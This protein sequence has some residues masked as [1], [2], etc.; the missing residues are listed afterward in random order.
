MGK[1][2]MQIMGGIIL[3]L[4]AA[5]VLIYFTDNRYSLSVKS[6][7]AL[8]D[9][10]SLDL[11]FNSNMGMG[12]DSLG[13]SGDTI[14]TME[15]KVSYTE[16]SLNLP[17]I[18]NPK[19]VDIYTEDDKVY[20]KYNLSFLPWQEGMPVLQE[21]AFN[22][23]VFGEI[24]TKIN[25]MD[26]LKFAYI[27]DKGKDEDVVEYYTTDFFTIEEMKNMLISVLSLDP[28]QVRS[29]DIKAYEIKIAFHKERNELEFLSVMFDY[30]VSGIILNNSFR[31]N[32]NSL[33][34]VAE[35][36]VPEGLTID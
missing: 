7:M 24:N 11:S 10:E 28:E 31:L 12:E 22:P 33:N 17:A 27:L 5:L 29:W 8:R 25:V 6:Y 9:A 18:G 3:I 2:I 36:P 21:D 14:L 15:P 20:H 19:I 13:I 4:V 23:A 16:V 32:I 30:D 1:R 35:I 34:T 26:L